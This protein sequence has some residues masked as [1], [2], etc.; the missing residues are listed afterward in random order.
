[1]VFSGGDYQVKSKRKV[2][3][4]QVT[5]RRLTLIGKNLFFVACVL[6]YLRL[7]KIDSD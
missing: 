5:F 7:L 3:S 1:M 2:F 4:K 6:S